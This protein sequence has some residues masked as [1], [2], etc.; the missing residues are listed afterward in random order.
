M[1]ILCLWNLCLI[2][3]TFGTLLYTKCVVLVAS[4]LHDVESYSTDPFF[5]NLN[6]RYILMGFIFKSLLLWFSG[7]VS[8]LFVSSCLFYL[9]ISYHLHLS[10]LRHMYFK[11]NRTLKFCFTRKWGDKNKE[12]I[13][14][15]TY[16]WH[17]C[18]LVG[19]LCY[20]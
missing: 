16:V 3:A 14:K 20:L 12:C 6:T 15:P 11:I 2:I 8:L 13:R 7:C 10:L 9:F 18:H 1:L 5:L 17:S 4:W 19:F